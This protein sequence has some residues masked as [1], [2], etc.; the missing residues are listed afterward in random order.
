MWW[1]SLT[2]PPDLTGAARRRDRPVTGRHRRHRQPT[3]SLG[4]GHVDQRTTALGRD[5][6]REAMRVLE[7]GG[8]RAG[9]RIQDVVRATRT[10]AARN[11]VEACACAHAVGNRVIGAGTVAAHPE[12]AD[13]L[14]AG[15]QR[16]AATEGNDATGYGTMT[17]A[18]FQKIRIERI[19][20]VSVRRASHPA[21]SART[22][23]RW[24]VTA[25]NC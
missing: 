21:A 24:K 17:R 5:V 16:K 25:Q 9:G 13:H 2:E 20:I 12:P 1:P 22:D 3:H 4:V 7:T 10:H 14:T 23:S 19:R 15:I 18:H 8:R 11:V 6:T